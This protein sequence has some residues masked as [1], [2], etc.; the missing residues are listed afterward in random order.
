[1]KHKS[2]ITIEYKFSCIANPLW[3]INQDIFLPW[4][5]AASSSRMLCWTVSLLIWQRRVPFSCLTTLKLPHVSFFWQSMLHSISDLTSPLITKPAEFLFLSSLRK[6]LAS[7]SAAWFK[8]MQ[9]KSKK[10][11]MQRYVQ[12]SSHFIVKPYHWRSREVNVMWFVSC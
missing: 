11:P 12:V 5:D 3:P 10:I 9:I 7:I 4:T 8:C 6:C 2:S 1:M